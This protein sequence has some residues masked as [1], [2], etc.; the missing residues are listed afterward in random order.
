MVVRISKDIAI[1]PPR[2]RV[3]GI[4]RCGYCGHV[5]KPVKKFSWKLFLLFSLSGIGG[6]F[7][8]M[9]YPFKRRRCPVCGDKHMNDISVYEKI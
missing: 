6:I 2:S 3:D 7:Y 4:K 9:Y 8:L 5:G 1:K